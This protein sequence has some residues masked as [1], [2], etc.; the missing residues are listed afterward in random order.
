[1]TIKLFI[2]SLSFL[3]SIG[4][5]S[6][7]QTK[8]SKLS[9]DK[10][11]KDTFSSYTGLQKVTLLVVFRQ[12]LKFKMA[13]VICPLNKKNIPPYFINAAKLLKVS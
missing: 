4:Q 7:A 5:H 8:Y 12:T 10:Q 6:N 2:F 13:V 9:V 1:M 11:M 3:F